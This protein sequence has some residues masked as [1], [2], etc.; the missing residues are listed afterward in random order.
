LE[1]EKSVDYE[2][3]K[4]IANSKNGAQMKYH[5]IIILIASIMFPSCAT[6]LKKKTYNMKISSNEINAKFKYLIPYIRYLQ[7]LM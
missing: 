7:K 4:K 1:K 3:N 5:I 6:I 2:Y